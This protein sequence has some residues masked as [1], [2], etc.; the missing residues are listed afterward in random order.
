[1]D[2]GFGFFEFDPR[3]PIDL[4][5][6]E[7]LVV[8]AQ[9]KVGRVHAVILPEVAV[10]V[11]EIAA[12][13]RRLEAV[14]VV[15]LLAGAREGAAA[16]RMGRNFVHLGARTRQGWEHFQQAKHHRWCLDASQVR[17]YHLSPVLDPS[18]LWWEAIDL[19]V[20]TAEIIDVGGGAT[21]ALLICED[22][23]RLDEVAD[24]LR[25]V[26]PSLVVALLLDGPQLPQRWPSRY[27]SVLSDEPGSAVLTLT[28]F[29][30]VARSRPAGTS[31]SRAV[32]MWSEPGA[33]LRHL[34]LGNGAKGIVATLAVDL[35]T[36]WTAD[37]R[38]HVN[39][40]PAITL[41][42]VEQLRGHTK[43]ER[44]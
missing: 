4:D 39:N 17:Q 11:E 22:L 12:V 41:R 25:R 13:E 19:P 37:G 29:G 23:A 40:T 5:L 36:V 7:R 34:D 44:A 32:A 3:D 2:H 31:R 38:R 20:R 24:V 43:K 15:S 14:G 26:G 16:G 1:M 27:A 35:K 18:R 28:S 9:R 30:M 33:G 6:I 8:E 10:A 42:R 21:I